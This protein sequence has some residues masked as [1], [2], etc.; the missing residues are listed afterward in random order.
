VTAALFFALPGAE[1]R[2]VLRNPKVVTGRQAGRSA[3]GLLAF[4][5]FCD[6]IVSYC[7]VPRANRDA[8]LAMLSGL[9]SGSVDDRRLP[10][11]GARLGGLTAHVE[12][13]SLRGSPSFM[14]PGQRGASGEQGTQLRGN[15]ET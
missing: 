2:A 8:L 15:C 4:Y 3:D 7:Y 11:R 6:F 10:S 12:H 9:R 1:R 13:H 14:P 5:S